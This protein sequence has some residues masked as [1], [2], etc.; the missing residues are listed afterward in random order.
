MKLL[1]VRRCVVSDTEAFSKDETAVLN[2]S[3]VWVL[4]S[5]KSTTY[6]ASH[7]DL[8]LSNALNCRSTVQ[9]YA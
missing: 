9:V 8:L 1:H 6:S 7:G 2:C 4:K 3:L 5:N